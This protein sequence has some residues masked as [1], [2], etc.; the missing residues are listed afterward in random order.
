MRPER[1]VKEVLNLSTSFRGKWRPVNP[2]PSSS[3]SVTPVTSVW[4]SLRFSSECF[5]LQTSISSPEI[6][7]EEF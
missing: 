1:T 7:A 6:A 5:D 2:S 4:V 3:V